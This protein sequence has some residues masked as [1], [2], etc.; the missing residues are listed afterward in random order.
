MCPTIF[1]S[2]RKNRDLAK[3]HS[4][5]NG[6][7]PNITLIGNRAL[8]IFFFFLN[9]ALAKFNSNRK[10]SPSQTKHY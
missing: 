5:R 10:L 9:S 4:N 6:P 7:Y 3:F 8:A 1:H 2:N